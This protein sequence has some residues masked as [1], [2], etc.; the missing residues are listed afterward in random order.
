MAIPRFVRHV[1]RPHG[2]YVKMIAV[3]LLGLCFIFI[4]SMFSSSS[5]SL[6]FQRSS[7][8]DI[9]E[10]VAAYE[11]GR[12]YG[13]QPKKK[14]VDKEKVVDEKK[15]ES[16]SRG[17]DEKK[18]ES[19]ES[20]NDN[21]GKKDEKEKLD[22]K[23][24]KFDPNKQNITDGQEESEQE[25][26]DGRK[27]GEDE[28]GE[29]KEGEGERDGE[30]NEEIE[31]DGNLNA[32]EEEE[33]LEKIEHET[34]TTGKKRKKLGPLFEKRT[35][36]SWK[37]CSVR[38]KHNYIPC[39]DIERAT[40]KLQSYRHHERSC[41]KTPPMCLVS[42]PP[43]GYEIPVHWPES[44]SKILYKNV[45]HPRLASFIKNQSWVVQSEEHLTFPQNQ[46]EFKGG[47][48]H[49]IDSI[50]EMVPDIEWGKNIRVVL[51]VGCTDSS[52]A[53]TL[54]DKA[55]LTL[56]LGLKD[57]L[58]DLAQVSLERGFPTIVSPF[59][60]RRVPFP[61]GA[62]D[63]IHC[64]GCTIPWHS[65]G[66][67]LLLEIN[68]I[69]R[70]GGYFI[71]STRHDSIEEEEAMLT[72][73]ASMCWN[74][75]AHKTE[76]IS[77]VGVKIYQKPESN[78]IFELRR[79]KNPSICKEDENPDVAWYVPIKTCL[80]TIPTSIEQHG[81]EWPE[82]WPKR[83]E[84]YP[85][86]LDNKENVVADTEHWKAIVEKSYLVGMGINWSHV[87]NI[88]DM[89]S[90]YGGCNQP[91]GIVVEMDRILRPGGWVI[92]RDKVEILDS[93][94]TILRSLHWDIRMTYGKDKEGIMCAQKTYW[95]P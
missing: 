1:K 55:V 79:K 45:E 53:D 2:F 35:H 24:E 52:F 29:D 68:R 47:A 58:V 72:L 61:S 42:L 95:R 94:E 50:V 26:S 21:G 69:L 9:A 34:R 18:E 57:D 90:I 39:I 43:K 81:S 71:L 59:R 28:V 5:T 22:Q 23:K 78:D 36:Y 64:G 46:S 73:T 92:I 56:S 7:F 75:L 67:K 91:I 6:I 51:D 31:G 66:G 4:W 41:P 33:P 83:L 54:L 20:A 93:L 77:E 40:Q 49:Y 48:L 62:F 27:E 17:K 16:D 14:E 19:G 32:L 74:T 84:N 13:V 85:E 3:T 65:N 25:E 87:R 63:V 11:R 37:I 15:V 76:E 60:T 70:P 80:H 10:P 44:K 12:D 8:S 30:N 86:W 38:S 88:M 82:E 89:K